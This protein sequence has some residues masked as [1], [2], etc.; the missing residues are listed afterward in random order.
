M[1]NKPA[2]TILAWGESFDDHED[3][4]K[5]DYEEDKCPFETREEKLEKKGVER[6]SIDKKDKRK[7]FK[8]GFKWSVGT[9]DVDK[10]AP[11]QLEIE[12]RKSL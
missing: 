7:V 3:L 4:L 12:T 6:L 9:E 5:R 2:I 8:R 11:P 10:L 1:E